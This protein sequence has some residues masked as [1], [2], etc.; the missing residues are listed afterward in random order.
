MSSLFIGDCA[1]EQTE[2][3]NRR[4]DFRNGLYA[5]TQSAGA[6]KAND[7]KLAK[8]HRNILLNG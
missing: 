2:R 6:D 5:H 4:T 8:E 1:R 3:E 7:R